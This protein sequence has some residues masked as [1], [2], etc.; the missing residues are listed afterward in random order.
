[1][2]P[3]CEAGGWVQRNP[4]RVPR[5]RSRHAPRGVTLLEMLVVVTI[6][7]ILVAIL[8]PALNGAR[9]RARATTCSNNLRQLGV[10][11]QNRASRHGAYCSG[12]FDWFADGCAVERSWVADLVDL[13]TPVG[14]ML[15]PTNPAQVAETYNDL[16]AG[17]FTQAANYCSS[18]TA[19][20]LSGKPAGS[21]GQKN[22]CRRMMEEFPDGATSA[23][24]TE[25]VAGRILEEHYNT[26]YTA[27][28]FLVRSGIKIDE[29]TGGLVSC[30][31][32][33]AKGH[34]F[35]RKNTRGPLVQ[36]VLDG[37][38]TPASL[39]PL[40]AD[41]G[42]SEQTL[43]SGVGPHA[44]GAE[45]VVSVTAGPVLESDMTLPSD[46][47]SDWRTVW[48]EQTRQDFRR[49]RPVHR[50]QCNILFA[51][52]SVRSVTD[53]DEDGLL[54]NGFPAGSAT[55]FAT[56]TVELKPEDVYSKAYI[57]PLQ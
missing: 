4:A 33:G 45:M 28:W 38:K 46:N 5:L 39:L 3:P 54:N 34:A 16:L 7:G 2:V 35:C 29:A 42:L 51:D 24:R 10:G 22:A 19:D 49:L 56:D 18:L 8:F 12:A 50:G 27:S 6:I 48:T 37:S 47:P 13:G 31:A 52:G 25:M 53:E 41:G 30:P 20:D 57:R 26:N 23:A 44:A 36:A 40:L 17:D 15:C 21:D 32:C 1:M 43:V 14:S 9:D 55:G 11:L